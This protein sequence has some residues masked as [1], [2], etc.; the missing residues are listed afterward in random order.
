[1]KIYALS[2]FHCPSSSGC[3]PVA[4]TA[5]LS[6]FAFYTKTPASDSSTPPESELAALVSTYQ[7]PQRADALA[8]VQNE[9]DETRI[10]L[11]QTIEAMLRRGE[12]LDDLVERSAALGAQTKMFYRTTRQQNSCCVIG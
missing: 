8:R 11:H 7:D 9:L 2:I 5:D 6:S 10:V 12:R 1:M 3:T 4:S